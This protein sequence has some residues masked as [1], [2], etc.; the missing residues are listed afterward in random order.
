MNYRE[1]L[2]LTKKHPNPFSI[3]HRNTRMYDFEM[4]EDVQKATDNIKVA[5]KKTEKGEQQSSQ[6]RQKA[7]DY[8]A[9]YREVLKTCKRHYY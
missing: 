2:E 8:S 5:I 6:D 9:S 3:D 4:E 7:S 1:L